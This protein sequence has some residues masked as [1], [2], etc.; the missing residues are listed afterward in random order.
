MNTVS[1]KYILKCTTNI[2]SHAWKLVGQE[3]ILYKVVLFIQSNI[4][5]LYDGTVSTP[6]F[7]I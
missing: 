3:I 5:L 4:Q 1:I 7:E 2:C 6:H